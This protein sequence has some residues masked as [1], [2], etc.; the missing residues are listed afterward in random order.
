VYKI[1]NTG[2]L[3]KFER[4]LKPL[5]SKSTL[6]GL[7]VPIKKSEFMSLSVFGFSRQAMT[8]AEEGQKFL[9]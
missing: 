7:F 3:Q 9:K 6:K 4:N 5:D 8:P 2:A 1:D